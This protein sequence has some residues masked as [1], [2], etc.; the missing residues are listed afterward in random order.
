MTPPDGWPL[1][2]AKLDRLPPGD[3]MD[4]RTERYP[5]GTFTVPLARMVRKFHLLDV[6]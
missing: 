1:S 6:I 3:L 5:G 4:E 2:I